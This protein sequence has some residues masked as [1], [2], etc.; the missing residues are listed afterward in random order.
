MHFWSF[1]KV[2]RKK[3]LP[4]NQKVI[5]LKT[6]LTTKPIVPPTKQKELEHMVSNF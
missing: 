5:P 2:P 6:V 4:T 1:I 3:V